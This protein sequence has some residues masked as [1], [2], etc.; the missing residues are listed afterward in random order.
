[1]T[2]KRSQLISII[3]LVLSIAVELAEKQGLL[4]FGNPELPWGISLGLIIAA[5]SFNV[6][7]IRN[8]G[9]P[10]K[11]RQ[12]SQRLALIIAIYAF[13]VFALEVI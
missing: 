1:M 5:L 9:A 2:N 8:L 6:K 7:V 3:C 11:E 4:D 10:Q 13:L 12:Q